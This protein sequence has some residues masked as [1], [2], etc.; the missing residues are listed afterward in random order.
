MTRAELA[1][2]AGVSIETLRYYERRGL[3]P[4]PP[5][6]QSGY[7]QYSGG[8]LSRL[9]FIRNGQRVGFSLAEIADLTSLQ[10]SSKASCAEVW[11]RAE[12]KI[13]DTEDRIRALQ[14]I[15]DALQRL[16][17]LCSADERPASEC[18]FLSE[19]HKHRALEQ[20]L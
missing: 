14:R 17:R 20:S 6:N 9:W 3:L 11:R 4:E 7:R 15:R 19:L 13:A 2:A 5:R 16:S 18:G 10:V 1:R 8:Y 12:A